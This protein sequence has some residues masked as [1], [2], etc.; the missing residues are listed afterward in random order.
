MTCLLFSGRQMAALASSL[1][2]FATV[3]GDIEQW[4]CLNWPASFDVG[5]AK[6]TSVF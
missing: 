4:P 2:G 1:F 5:Y 3:R 6:M